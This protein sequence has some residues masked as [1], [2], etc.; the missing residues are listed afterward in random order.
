M[1]SSGILIK[2]EQSRYSRARLEHIAHL[3]TVCAA[4][5]RVDRR[6]RCFANRAD[7]QAPRTFVCVPKSEM[8]HRER[9]SMAG[10]VVERVI[11]AEGVSTRLWTIPIASLVSLR[12]CSL[13]DFGVSDAAAGLEARFDHRCKILALLIVKRL[14][15]MLEVFHCIGGFSLANLWLTTDE[16][17]RVGELLTRAFTP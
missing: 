1:D 9:D 17:H 6:I 5:D 16:L 7:N 3:L 15:A 14:T 4:V 13:Y 10:L 8:L 2:F 11:A 12:L